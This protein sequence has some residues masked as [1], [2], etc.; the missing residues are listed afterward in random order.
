MT[1][2]RLSRPYLIVVGERYNKDGIY[3]AYYLEET[4]NDPA[5]GKSEI[6]GFRYAYYST[7]DTPAPTDGKNVTM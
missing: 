4:K 7:I 3:V 1:Y 5:T 2:V 6:L